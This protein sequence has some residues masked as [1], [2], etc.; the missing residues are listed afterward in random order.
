L[1]LFAAAKTLVGGRTAL[2]CGAAAALGALALVNRA[3]ARRAERKHPPRGEFIEVDGVRLHYSDRGAGQPIVLIH[4]NAVSGDDWNT[5]GVADLLL[6]DGHRV[7]VFDRP[8]FGHSERPRGRAWTAMQ[9]AELL[10]KALKQLG[11]E[12]PVVVGHSW[13]TIVALSMAVRRPADTAGLVLLSGYYFWTL[14]P[15]AL[16]VAAGAIPVLGDVLRYTVSPWLGRLLMPLQK[17]AMFSPAAVTEPF[18]REYSDAMALRPSQI[19]ATSMDGA[20]M[21]PGA[22]RLRRRY[23][24]LSMPVLI[25]A[26]SGDKIVFKRNAERLQASIPGSDLRVVEGAGHMV[27][28]SAPRRVVEAIRSVAAASAGV[29]AAASREPAGPLRAVPAGLAEAA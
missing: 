16:L 8:G 23:D 20:L 18:K 12:R 14:R 25:M 13:G 22:L 24:E 29:P 21:I 9:Q 26:G 6:R 28:H 10:H 17:R 7:I 2:A 27:H 3:A 15:D 5:S 4:G 1:N 19:R 11:I